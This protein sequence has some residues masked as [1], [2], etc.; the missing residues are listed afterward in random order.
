MLAFWN[1]VCRDACVRDLLLSPPTEGAMSAFF[2]LSSRGKDVPSK[3]G[4]LR[5]ARERLDYVRRRAVEEMSRRIDDEDELFAVGR[6]NGTQEL[7]GQR[8]LQIATI[9]R[10]LSFEDDNTGLL[11]K[12]LTCLRFVD[13]EFFNKSSAI[14]PASQ[15]FA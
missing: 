8:V 7:A 3:A 10:N 2:T 9:I 1:D 11:A 13:I 15:Y 5:N 4:A 14:C 6:L 12:N